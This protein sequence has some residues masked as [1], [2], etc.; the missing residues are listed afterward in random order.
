MHSGLNW[1]LKML[2]LWREET[3]EARKKPLEQGQEPTTN[4]THIMASTHQ[5]IEP[6]PHLWVASALTTAPSLPAQKA[7][8]LYSIVYIV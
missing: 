3:E 2:V 6:E 8:G 7:F 5:E 4:S 1:D